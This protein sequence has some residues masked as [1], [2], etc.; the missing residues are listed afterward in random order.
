MSVHRGEIYWVEFSP[1]KGSEQG[2]LR[3]ALVVQQDVGN[4]FSPTTV[5]A[6]ITSSIPPKPYPFVVVLEPGEGGLRERSTINCAQL[7]TIHQSGSDSRLRPP[8]GEQSVRPLG[9]LSS[10]R[11]AQV[12]AALKYNLGLSREIS[13]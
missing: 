5:V 9:V 13:K 12:D 4:L 7:T 11:M 10:K 2:G 8:P 3:P 1:V 6:A